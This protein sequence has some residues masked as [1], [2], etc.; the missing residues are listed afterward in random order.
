MQLNIKAFAW[1]VS[2]FAGA[3]WFLMM[4]FSLLTGVG[5]R[6]VATLGSYHPFFSYSWWGMVIIVVEHL[7]GGF[8]VGWIFAWLYNKMLKKGQPPQV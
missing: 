7:I 8:I 5:E 3:C 2:V 1:T 4:V 6:T